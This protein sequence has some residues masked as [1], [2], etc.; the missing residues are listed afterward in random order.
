MRIGYTVD[1]RKDEIDRLR[2]VGCEKIIVE[3]LMY[4]RKT[5]NIQWNRLMDQLSPEDTLVLV[6]LTCLGRTISE[7]LR[8]FVQ[9]PCE[10]ELLDDRLE[11]D[12]LKKMAPILLE[13]ETSVISERTKK[14]MEKTSKKAGR[15]KKWE[16]PAFQQKFMYY[17]RENL[18]VNEVCG[19]LG[20]SRSTFY[21]I[22]HTLTEEQQKQM[23]KE[24]LHSELKQEMDESLLK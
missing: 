8:A 10:V 17:V 21:R 1:G 18:S 9:V 4:S 24:K 7:M 6:D 23:A 15:I 19:I 13:M 5:A 11:L 22:L 20:I 3:K 12:E 16:D 14:G 2:F